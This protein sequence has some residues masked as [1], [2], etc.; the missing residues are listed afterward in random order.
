MPKTEETAFA[1]EFENFPA[2][3]SSTAI[4][5]VALGPT[6][7]EV[8]VLIEGGGD[9]LKV[10]VGNG[11]SNADAPTEIAQLLRDIASTLENED[12]LA[13]YDEAIVSDRE[14]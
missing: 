1:L 4:R 12:F 9:T 5:T 10:T 7:D 14:E 8:V 3:G 2:A 11:P 13:A 6:S